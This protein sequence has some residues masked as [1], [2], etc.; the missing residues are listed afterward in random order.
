M[1]QIFGYA[2]VSTQDQNLDT[3]LDIL[4]KAGCNRIFQDKITGV[5]VQRPAL[6]E[7][8]GLLREGDTVLVARFFRLG[9]SRDHVIHLINL[10]YQRGVHFKALDLGIDT[11]TP[12]GKFILSIF[13]SLAEYDRESI[14]EKTRA[15]QQLAAAQGKHI[16]RPK[17]LDTEN[18]AKVKKA[19]EKGL[20]VAETVELTRISLSSVKRYRKYLQTALDS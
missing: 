1:N 12:A 13:A 9:R 14:L 11:N 10:F 6:D 8:I 4:T 3:Q 16:G 2:R 15:G 18:L 20:S 7:M 19:L 5:S 17:G